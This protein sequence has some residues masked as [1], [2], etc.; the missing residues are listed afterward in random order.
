MKQVVLAGLAEAVH[1]VCDN[2]DLKLK[3]TRAEGCLVQ[4]HGL[5]ETALH[6][7]EDATSRRSQLPL[8]MV[9]SSE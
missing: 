9:P 1:T 7:E 2:A 6:K 4:Q 5:W 3:P 8:L